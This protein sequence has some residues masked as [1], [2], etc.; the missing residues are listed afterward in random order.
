M[1]NQVVR[2]QSGK[3]LPATPGLHPGYGTENRP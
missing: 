1:T 2:M 3:S